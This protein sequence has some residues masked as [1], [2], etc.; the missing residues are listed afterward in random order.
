MKKRIF[1]IAILTVGLLVASCG[2][3]SANNAGGGESE[4]TEVAENLPELKANYEVKTFT[5]GAPE[6]WSCYG[7]Y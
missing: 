6:G 5:A 7:R 2:N 4:N 3:K 1:S